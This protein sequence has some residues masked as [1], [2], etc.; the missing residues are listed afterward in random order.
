MEN[1]IRKEEIAKVSKDL[2][3]KCDFDK[4]M[5]LIKDNKIEFDYK[6]KKYRVKLLNSLE[7]SE[8]DILRRKKF[9]ELLQD[10]NILFEKEIIRL[11]KERGIDI[12]ENDNQIK[13]L[14]RELKD[15][16]YKLGESIDQKDD[17]SIWKSYKDDIEAI[18][19]EMVDLIMKKT[20]LLENSF[21]RTLEHFVIEYV[22]YLSLEVKEGETFVKAFNSNDEF[23][24]SEEALQGV[25]I[26]YSMALNQL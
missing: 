5:E 13:K 12:E 26:T 8:L 7:K 25:A 1:E 2:I 11:Y 24:K 21:E 4:I 10:K 16:M 20:Q 23:L 6:D 18:K 17:E 22:S 14:Q 3:D 15:T 19:T 9:G